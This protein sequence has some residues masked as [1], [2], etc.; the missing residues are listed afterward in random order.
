MSALLVP[1]VSA[2]KKAI[3]ATLGPWVLWVCKG[4]PVLLVRKASGAKKGTEGMSGPPVPRGIRVPKV[5]AEKRATEA[6][7]VHRDR[8]AILAW[9][10]RRVRRDQVA[11]RVPKAR[12][13]RP[14]RRACKVPKVCKESKGRGAPKATTGSR[15]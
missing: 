4:I 8:K 12:R 15:V 6:T 3:E 10:D 14:V 2:A 5:R 11:L 13:G 1:K 7:P 9:P